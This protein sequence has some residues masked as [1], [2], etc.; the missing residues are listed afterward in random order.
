MLFILL[1]IT[2]TQHSMRK[3]TS[4]STQQ[5]SSSSS[6]THSTH[7]HRHHHDEAA[8][9]SVEGYVLIMTNIHIEA[10]ESDIIDGIHNNGDIRLAGSIKQCTLPLDRQSGYVCGYVLL[11]VE[12]RGDAEMI[13]RQMNGR[14]MLG[15]RVTVDYA[16]TT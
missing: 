3:M 15:Q 4:A 2:S 7:P 14:E 12:H 1:T 8:I 5:Q 9:R 6:I 11:E 13:V 10:I 16:F